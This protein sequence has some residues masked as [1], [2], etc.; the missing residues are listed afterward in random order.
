MDKQE[1]YVEFE[2]EHTQENSMGKNAKNHGNKCCGKQKVHQENY[3]TNSFPK[4]VLCC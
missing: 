2:Q 1:V 3:Q 4:A